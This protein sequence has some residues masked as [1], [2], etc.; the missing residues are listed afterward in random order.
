MDGI[1]VCARPNS[2][3]G[4]CPGVLYHASSQYSKVCGR[5]IG[6]QFGSPS[7]FERGVVEGRTID[8]AYVEGVSIT[9]GRNPR[10]HIWSYAAGSSEQN[11]CSHS[12]CPCV[13]I[14][15]HEPPSYVGN[16]YFCESAYQGTCYLSNRFFPD[17]PLWDGQQCDNDEDTC[18]TGANTPPWF[19][20]DLPDSTSDDIEVRI[21]HDQHIYILEMKILQFS[22]WNSMSSELHAVN[23]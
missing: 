17:D 12:K 9:H 8:E 1:R 10:K 6:Y 23:F 7:A 16:N 22:C 21:C 3:E 2:T 19:S 20:M 13:N 15:G 4:T 18:C 5:V 11:G 14:G